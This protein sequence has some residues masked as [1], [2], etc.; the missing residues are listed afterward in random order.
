[1]CPDFVEIQQDRNAQN[2]ACGLPS[3]V[4]PIDW[5]LIGQLA[6][7]KK[8]T[9]VQSYLDC[10]FENIAAP[11]HKAIAEHQI[12]HLI[13][14]QRNEEHH[15]ATIRNG[16]TLFGVTRIHPIEHWTREGVLDY[17]KQEM[18]DVP[19]H[20]YLNHSSMDCYDCT[21]YDKV[22]SDRHEFTKRHPSLMSAFESRKSK[23]NA[24]LK[25]VSHAS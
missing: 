6:T 18:G 15:K 22:A 13:A 19:E 10:C 17:L 25:E 20:L 1:M 9:M 21:A 7:G 23:L 16:D 4:V 3:D 24:V 2:E 14:G 12:T 5:T 11:L 8:D